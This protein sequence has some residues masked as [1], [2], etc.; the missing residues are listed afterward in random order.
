MR[1][2]RGSERKLGRGMKI[3]ENEGSESMRSESE[4]RGSRRSEEKRSVK[5]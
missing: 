5:K 3:R 2:G 4:V 1:E